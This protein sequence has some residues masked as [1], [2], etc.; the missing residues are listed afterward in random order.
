MKTQATALAANSPAATSPAATALKRPQEEL[1]R[2][3]RLAVA[4]AEIGEDARSRAQGYRNET[5]V[6]EGG[7]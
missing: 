2:R 7:E 5:L 4:L 3:Q 1:D 6:P